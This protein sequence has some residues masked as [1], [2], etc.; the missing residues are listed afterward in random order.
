LAAGT[1]DGTRLALDD[2]YRVTMTIEGGDIGGR[3]A[4]NSYGGTLAVSDGAVTVGDL[5]WTE[6]ACE[7]AVMEIESAFLNGLMRVRT[8]TR[9]TDTASLSGEGVEFSFTLLTPVPTADLI[10]VT[11]VLDTI[12]EGDT[13]SSTVTA[14]HPATLHLDPDGTFEGSTGCRA[15]SGEY[16][17]AG[18][19]V[20][21]TSFG[22]AGECPTDLA[23]QDGHVI[24][25][26][27]DA[28]TVSIDGN[29]L[30]L[31]ARGGAGLSYLA[32]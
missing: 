11:W 4:C 29:R 32:G 9:T 31:T 24:A 8:A 21:F 20:R 30:T 12:I 13:A 27:E 22:A 15:V 5:A 16:V 25:V 19:T 3:A 10:G 26:L 17:V 6:M 18:D 2:R 1:V 14:A 28:F 23:R 7:P